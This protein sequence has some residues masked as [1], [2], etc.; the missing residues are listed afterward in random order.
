MKLPRRQFLHLAAGAAVLPAAPRMA[1]AQEYPTRAI[2]LVVPFP[3]GGVFDFVGRPLAERMRPVLGTVFIENIGGGGGSLGGATV[4]HA[5]PDG[6]TLL[7]GST[8][9]YVIEVLL[10]NRPQYDPIKD[11]API[12]NVEINTFAIAVHPAV[13]AHT[14]KEF[15]DYVKANSGKASYGSAGAG[16]LNHL[17]GELFK[18][19]S[20]L[21]DLIH[22]P[23]RGAG[24]AIIDLLAGQIPMI[25]PAM[26]GQVLQL[27]RAGKLRILAVVSP[28]RL[29]GTPDLPTAV[30]QGFFGLIALQRIGLIA[31]TGTRTPILA[32]VAQAAHM[33]L[34][35]RAFQQ[36]LIEAGLEPDLDSNPEKFRRSLEE[37]VAHWTPVANAI[38]FKID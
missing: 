14:L 31:P 4:A 26:S 28:N 18:L 16:T 3:P 12:A 35:D 5:Q 22:V 15:V 27:H 17:T 34:A 11:L 23:Y 25:I 36:M 2:R 37:D 32:Q 24:P 9:Q 38:G 21:P 8:V 20:G 7:L 13:P 10:K 19:Q 29:A 30:E 1:R 33:A 6:Y